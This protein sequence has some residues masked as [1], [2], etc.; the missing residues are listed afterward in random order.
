MKEKRQ[1]IDIVNQLEKEKKEIEDN[2]YKKD[3][4]ANITKPKIKLKADVPK[5][6]QNIK[7]KKKKSNGEENDE[8]DEENTLKELAEELKEIEKEIQW[9]KYWARKQETEKINEKKVKSSE[10]E[11]EY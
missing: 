10:D 3:K 9:Y 5:F 7:R 1:L 11:Y 6:S 8:E 2:E 4:I